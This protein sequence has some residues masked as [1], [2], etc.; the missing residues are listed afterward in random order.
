MTI[1]RNECVDCGFP[2]EGSSCQNM[3]VPH[4]Y[5]DEC[6]TETLH[7]F[8]V[9]GTEVC[10]KCLHSMFDF[11]FAEDDDDVCEDC[12]K[13]T[14]ILYDVDGTEVCDKCFYS[15]FPEING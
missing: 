14:D 12:G 11:R 9:D 2:C 8:D 13:S 7:L 15:Y 5:C 1:Y 4:S 6:G 3:N 10:E